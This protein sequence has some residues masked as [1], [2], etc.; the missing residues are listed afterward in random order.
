MVR[1]AYIRDDNAAFPIEIPWMVLTVSRDGHYARS[2]RPPGP[3]ALRV[4]GL[5]APSLVRLV[6]VMDEVRLL[7]LNVA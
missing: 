3:S 7:E 4:V 1:F 5:V 2:R 6:P